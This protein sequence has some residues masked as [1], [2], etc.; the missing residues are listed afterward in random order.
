MR[1]VIQ[2]HL[3]SPSLQPRA[4][5]PNSDWEH[6]SLKPTARFHMKIT[7]TATSHVPQ[8]ICSCSPTPQVSP[9]TH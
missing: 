1:E 4:L 9:Q 2:V 7:S 5:A 3:Q 8:A 6:T